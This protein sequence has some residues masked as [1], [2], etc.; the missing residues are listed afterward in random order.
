[1]K[2]IF[3]V[4]LHRAASTSFQRWLKAGREALAG[5]RI[6]VAAGLS[7][8][9][10]EQPLSCLVGERFENLGPAAAAQS[11]GHEFARL[12][13]DYDIAVISEEN[14]PGMMAGRSP[15]AFEARD[16][17]ARLFELLRA[18]HEIVPVLILREHVSWLVSCYRV[19]QMRGGVKDFEE[20]IGGVEPAS[21]EFAPLVERLGAAADG[22]GP[23][24]GTLDAIAADGGEGFLGMIAKVLGTDAGLPQT[25]PVS[26]TSRLPL[27]C[28]LVQEA[29]RAGA[30]LA[31][32]GARPL[33]GKIARMSAG[34]SARGDAD[35]EKLARLMA[36]RWVEMPKSITGRSRKIAANAE[37]QERGPLPLSRPDLHKARLAARRAVASLDRPLAPPQFFEA[38]AQCYAADRRKV[39]ALYAPQ[40]LERKGAAA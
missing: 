12:A 19:Y 33:W 16:R 40:W 15:R 14:L 17:L 26:N 6:F 11:V 13:P 5:R 3:H 27:T 31:L 35:V 36:A 10:N 37:L 30:A 2:L 8:A 21:L 25:L 34:A 4:G 24:I 9:A 29:A 23:A 1:M 20:F 28:A 32:A 18:E 22:A 38:L 39:A 7:G